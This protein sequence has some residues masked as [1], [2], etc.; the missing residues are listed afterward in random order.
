M[1]FIYTLLS[2]KWGDVVGAHIADTARPLVPQT[3]KTISSTE[4]LRRGVC[5][6]RLQYLFSS[7]ALNQ[8]STVSVSIASTLH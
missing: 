5:A 8:Y 7:Q 1:H 6:E 2:L 3:D 4:I